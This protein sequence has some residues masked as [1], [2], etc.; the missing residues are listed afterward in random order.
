M[1][2]KDVKGIGSKTIEILKENNI[3]NINDL[4]FLF[5]KKYIIY[6]VKDDADIFE[7]EVLTIKAFLVSNPTFIKYQLRVNA[8]IFYIL[9]NNSKIKCILFSSDYLK[10]KL[11][12][13]SKVILNGKYN[14]SNNEFIVKRLF[15]DDFNSYVETDYKISKI[16]NSLIK[17]SI[18]NVLNSNIK[19]CESLPAELINKYKLLPI[20]EYIYFSHFPNNKNDVHQILRRRKFEEFFW[21][22]IKIEL[23]KRKRFQNIREEAFIDRKYLDEFYS[24][25]S[26][27]LTI[28]QKK[29]IDSIYEDRKSV[30]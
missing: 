22:A 18:Q 10:Y 7:G 25:L 20:T 14:P 15:L 3:N 29:A 26:F 30:V 23:L 16:S 24:L 8:I 5:P 19:V 27:E 4:I 11:F 12:N 9:Y 17:R 21:Y 13:G 2:L 6:D 28:D 1:E